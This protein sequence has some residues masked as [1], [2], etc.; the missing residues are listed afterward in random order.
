MTKVSTFRNQKIKSKVKRKKTVNNEVKAEISKTEHRHLTKPK[1]G[2]LKRS[3]KL[4]K[5][6]ARLFKEKK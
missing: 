3:T 5:F 6:T 2:S 1:A 4:K